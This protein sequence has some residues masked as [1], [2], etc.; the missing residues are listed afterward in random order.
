MIRPTVVIFSVIWP[1][2]KTFRRFVSQSKVFF[3]HPTT[4]KIKFIWIS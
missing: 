1:A 2:R 3:C 4:R